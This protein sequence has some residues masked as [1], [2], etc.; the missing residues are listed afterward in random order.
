MRAHGKKYNEAAKGRDIALRYEPK[1][2]IELVKQASYAKFDETVEVAVRL[3]VD[4]RHADQVVRG[5]V[6]LPAGTGKTVR[7]LVIAAGEK[8][9]EAEAAGADYVGTE[10]VQKIKDGW[11]D[12]DVLVATPDQMGQLG[13]LGRVLGPRGLMPNPKAGTVT[14]DIARAVRE[15]KAGKIEFRVDKAGN[16]HAA[17]GKVSFPAEALETNFTA[18]MDQIVRSKPSA[19]KGVYVRNVAISSTMGPGV[20]IDITPYR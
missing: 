1:Q 11:L 12:F 7:V 17:I 13:Q 16:V 18:F 5:T 4:P 20:A 14:F 10:Y 15:V 19:A 9:R 2:A 6:V 8:A 3:G